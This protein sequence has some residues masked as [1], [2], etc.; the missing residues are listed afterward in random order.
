MTP[1]ET[2]HYQNI[3]QRMPNDVEYPESKRYLI[4]ALSVI[5]TGNNRHY[6]AEELKAA[7]R[8]VGYR[9]ID[10]NHDKINKRLPE[11]HNQVIG[12]EYDEKT[13]SL[14][15]M[16]RVADPIVQNMIETGKIQKSSV[17]TRHSCSSGGNE[18]SDK[19]NSPCM[20][21]KLYFT[22]LALLTNDVPPGDPT[23]HIYGMES[24]HGQTITPSS[25]TLTAVPFESLLLEKEKMPIANSPPSQIQNEIMPED[26][27]VN[28]ASPTSTAPAPAA[29]ATPQPASIIEPAV[30][31]TAPAQTAAPKVSEASTAQPATYQQAPPTTNTNYIPSAAAPAPQH[32]IYS[33]NGSQPGAEM[34]AQIPRSIPDGKGVASPQVE[35]SEAAKFERIASMMRT[36]QNFGGMSRAGAEAAVTADGNPNPIGKIWLPDMITL[37][38]QLA[39]NL[40]STCRQET[41]ERGA[42][43]AYFFTITI[44]EFVQRV[45]STTENTEE[46]DQSHTIT[47]I[48]ATVKVKTSKNTVS[49]EAIQFIKGNVVQAIEQGFQEAAIISEDEEVLLGLDAE[50]DGS[51]AKAIFGDGSVTTEGTITSGMTFTEDRLLEAITEI[52]ANKHVAA[53]LVAV[54]HPRQAG[55]LIKRQAYKDA[56]ISGDNGGFNRSGVFDTKYGIELRV[57]TKVSTGLGSPTTV[58]TYRA[59]VYKKN[60][61]VGIAISKELDTEMLKTFKMSW[62]LRAFH[63]IVAKVLVHKAIVRIYTA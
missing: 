10:I 56:S 15:A 18:S 41:I 48:A 57:S 45:L 54:L 14:W 5:T 40:R 50:T 21:D 2:A 22:G 42:D 39:A 26:N 29:A 12:A 36:G 7:A 61:A 30:V 53:N 16:V 51:L 24:L 38:I 55:A 11:P 23:S 37:P 1:E 44:P 32:H 17:E 47:R 19:D 62:I 4:K 59:Y 28:T 20:V 27:K 13:N 9:H 43:T 52:Q 49:Y 35:G 33:T 63:Y 25:E 8:S 60:Y 46:A 3:I 31:S 58:T 6:S 34:V